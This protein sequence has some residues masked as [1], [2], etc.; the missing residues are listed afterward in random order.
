VL[1]LRRRRDSLGR[2]RVVD[3]RGA[4]RALWIR[5]RDVGLVLPRAGVAEIAEDGGLERPSRPR[6]QR[7]GDER[8]RDDPHSRRG[9]STRDPANRHA[10]GSAVEPARE[11]A[12]RQ[13]A[14]SPGR[15]ANGS[16]QRERRRHL[17]RNPLRLAA[18]THDPSFNR[19]VDSC[20]CPQ[21]GQRLD[22]VRSK[23]V[24]GESESARSRRVLHRDRELE[25][26]RAD[27]RACHAYAQRQSRNAV[28]WTEL[29]TSCERPSSRRE[30]LPDDLV[31][32]KTG[33]RLAPR[34]RHDADRRRRDVEGVIPE[35]PDEQA[36]DHCD[37]RRRSVGLDPHNHVLL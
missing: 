3:V 34:C 2:R 14:H 37:R 28:I 11:A 26:A 12:R 5:V 4:A 24:A 16:L 15:K 9:G 20:G 36:L 17:Q 19:T 29:G 21:S 22:D 31:R 35:A 18:N 23:R 25:G 30:A 6:R 13:S 1:G 27:R 33:L 32:T 10:D 7:R 8:P